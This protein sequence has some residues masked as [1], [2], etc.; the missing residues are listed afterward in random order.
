MDRCLTSIDGL[1]VSEVEAYVDRI[2]V[3][4]EVDECITSG[5]KYVV[6]AILSQVG[7]VP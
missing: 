2:E 4:Q 5:F 1:K 3:D 7:K 6:E